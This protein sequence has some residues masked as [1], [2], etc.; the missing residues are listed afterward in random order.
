MNKLRTRRRKPTSSI[1]NVDVSDERQPEDV[2]LDR[3]HVQAFWRA[4]D[5]LPSQQKQAIVLRE[6]RGASYREI[7]QTMQTS[8]SAVESLLFRARKGVKHGMGAAGAA[9]AA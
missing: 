2:L 5:R 3:L 9:A 4:V 1:E 6:V 8:E 7:A